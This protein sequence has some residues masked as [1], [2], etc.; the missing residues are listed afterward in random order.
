MTH[1]SVWCQLELIFNKSSRLD[2]SLRLASSRKELHGILNNLR[3]TL[4]NDQ[5]LLSECLSEPLCVSLIHILH[6]VC[7]ALDELLYVGEVTLCCVVL[8]KSLSL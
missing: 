4:F 7:T 1:P 5:P 6:C 8:L 3:A 2:T